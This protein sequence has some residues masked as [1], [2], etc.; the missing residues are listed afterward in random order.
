[1]AM[2]RGGRRPGAG[3]P[4]G[5]RNKRTL[6]LISKLDDLGCDPAAELLRLGREAEARGNLDLATRAYAV[7]MRYRWPMPA[8]LPV[9]P[10]IPL[11]ETSQPAPAPAIE[12]PSWFQ[13]GRAR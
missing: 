5:S 12:L 8:A 11:P 10:A 9:K 13:P 4:A 3:R 7:L 1:M 2:P 6:E